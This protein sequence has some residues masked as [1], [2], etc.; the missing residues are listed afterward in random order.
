MKRNQ[1]KLVGVNLG[2]WLVLEKWITPSLFEGTEAEDEFN[3]LKSGKK[4][5]VEKHYQNF[6]KEEDFKFLADTGINSLRI[7]VGYWL[8]GNQKPYLKTVNY[9]DFALKMAE[10]YG[11]KVLID[12]HAAPGSQNGYDHSGKVGEIGWDKEEK[13]VLETLEVIKKISER[14]C[15]S[16]ALF[17]IELLNEPHESI[18][19]EF[20]KDFY[21]KGY[22]I[23]RNICGKNVAVIISDSFRPY[24][25]TDYLKEKDYQNIFLDTHFYQCFSEEF[26]KIKFSAFLKRGKREWGST[27]KKMQKHLP[28]ISG[29]W[30]LALNSKDF[31]EKLSV[32]NVREKQI[33]K[34]YLSFKKMQ[35]KVFD[36][37]VGSFFWTYKT[38]GSDDLAWNFRKLVENGLIF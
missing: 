21:D 36:K 32:N 4:D 15:G 10:K 2:G 27:I 7:P 9:L 13:N 14:Y 6:I 37:S 28:M 12:L 24:E 11:L 31:S 26:Q 29:E 34:N 30:S 20:L 23:I 8:F 35:C 1:N 18:D 38:E 25:F 17:G 33:L 3:L 5:K 22:K 19:L 16:K